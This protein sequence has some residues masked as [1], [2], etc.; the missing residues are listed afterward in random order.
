MELQG[1]TIGILK[2]IMENENR[3]AG[4]PETVKKMVDN[5]AKVLVES[6]AGLG[7]FYTDAD[8][9]NAGAEII[10]DPESIYNSADVILKVKEP[11][12]NEAKNKHEVDMMKSNQVLISF[13]HPSNPINHDMVKKLA[14]KGVIGFSLDCIPRISRAQSMDAL[15]SMSTVAG[16]KAIIS[17]ACRLP[18]FIPMITT[19]VGMF[20]P[21]IVF[22][23]GTGVAGLQSL[24]TAKRLGAEI[25]AAD[26]RPDAVE[27]SKSLGAKIIDTGVPP[28]IAIGEGGYA[29]HLSDEW[30]HKERQSF[31][32]IVKKADIVVLS[33]LVPRKIAP[34]LVD[35]TMVRSMK[36][37]SVIV[38]IAIDQGGNCELTESGII[39]VKHNVTIDGT[40]NIPG[41]VALSASS[42]FAQN[43]LNFLSL[44]VKDGKINI[45]KSDE[46]IASALITEN[47]KIVNPDVLE[48]IVSYKEHR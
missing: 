9:K 15:T 8:Y 1:L 39:C 24:A 43:V 30:I 37:G 48:E 26:V 19:A 2:E 27:Q 25:Y 38:D 7:S 35:E 18:K 36:P 23:V 44:I 31:Y 47:G 20:R 41:S 3:V 29:R 10:N 17:A 6:G 46:I 34:I 11:L 28:E 14:Q 16:Y 4:I 22:V 12:M 42:M 33:A 40:K 5:G 32:E 21:A 45:N 13:L